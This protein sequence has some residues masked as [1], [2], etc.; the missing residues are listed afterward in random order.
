M[1]EPAKPPVNLSG[2]VELAEKLGYGFE[3]V[4]VDLCSVSVLIYV[5][6]LTHYTGAVMEDSIRL[7]WIGH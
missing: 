7:P 6:E 1:E 2:M 5:G 3:F 4:R